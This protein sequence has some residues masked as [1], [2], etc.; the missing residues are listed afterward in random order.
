MPWDE[1]L[2]R[3]ATFVR[4][5]FGGEAFDTAGRRAL[6]RL[7]PLDLADGGD[8]VETDNVMRGSDG[9]FYDIEEDSEAVRRDSDS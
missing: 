9:N 1:E 2:D 7:T 5:H 3:L 8:P 4:A 6:T